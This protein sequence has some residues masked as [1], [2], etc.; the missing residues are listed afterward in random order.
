MDKEIDEC[1]ECPWNYYCKGGCRSRIL[2][3]KGK[4]KYDEV[5]CIFN[6]I[7]YERIIENILDNI[8]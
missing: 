1:K 6:K 2:Y 5:E 4:M 3:S 7:M 8:H